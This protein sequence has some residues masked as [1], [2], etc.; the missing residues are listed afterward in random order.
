MPNAAPDRAAFVPGAAM[1]YVSL[2]VLGRA[3]PRLHLCRWGGHRYHSGAAGLRQVGVA[4]PHRHRP[5][6]DGRGR[7]PDGPAA[8]VTD[9]EDSGQASEDPITDGE[10]R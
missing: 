4:E 5:F 9:G 7:A 6:A 10:A 1:N 8:D 2:R 3:S